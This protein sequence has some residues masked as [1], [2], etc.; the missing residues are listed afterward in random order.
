MTYY[1]P[2][3]KETTSVDHHLT[4]VEKRLHLAKF[5]IENQRGFFESLRSV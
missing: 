1:Y 4:V 3:W 5:S 2:P